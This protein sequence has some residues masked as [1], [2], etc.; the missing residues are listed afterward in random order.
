MDFQTLINELDHKFTIDV[1]DISPFFVE[2]EAWMYS[3]ISKHYKES[4]ESNYRLVFYFEQDFH[5][6]ESY[7]GD[8]A[9]AFQKCITSMDISPFFVTLITSDTET[10]NDLILSKNILATDKQNFYNIDPTVDITHYVA[11]DITCS[12]TPPLSVKSTTN[13]K[14]LWNH[15]HINVNGD[16][17]PCCTSNHNY[18]LGNITQNDI[19]DIYQSPYANKIRESMMAGNKP[20]ACKSC[21]K[22]ESAGFKSPRV[23]MTSDELSELN[24][25]GTV[26]DVIINTIDIRLSNLCNLKCRMCTGN[27][28]SK[29]AKEE[30]DEF[31][32][33]YKTLKFN[34]IKNPNQILELLPQVEE[35][36]FA[37]GEPLL[38]RSH[39][40]I[41]D[42]LINLKKTD[43]RIGYNTNFTV[44]EYKN[45]PIADY[46]SQFSNI[47]VGAS[48]DAMEEHIEYIRHGTMWKDIVYNYDRIINDDTLDI[49]FS[50]TANINIFNAFNLI[51]S[52]QYWIT[53]KELPP[54]K[55]N[56]SILTD[57]PELSI[58]TLPFDYKKKLDT[59]ISNHIKF[60]N[61]HN[62]H[63]L[64][65]QW[66]EIRH[67]LWKS[68]NSAMLPKFFDNVDRLDIL[69]D[70]CFDE[71][72]GEYTDLRKYTNA[73]AAQE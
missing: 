51:H 34:D 40:Q 11:E 29:I 14:K 36:Y 4:Y 69:R 48:L 25:D 32:A 23:A 9:H 7:P 3:A 64:I 30:Y 67:F 39:Y 55:H 65:K 58:Q 50:I 66:E 21:Y 42:E 62:G 8:L 16:V 56:I 18:S 63:G 24:K 57:P 2:G 44:I 49:D 37:G 1:I 35:I 70:E 26:D 10:S 52:Q 15:L 12:H 28:S 73:S 72:F 20:I 71:V 6:Y 22:L 13:C 68:D 43:I 17:L 27:Y 31:G 5:Q 61:G 53:D 54:T 33:E 59:E 19:N 47:H 46:W 38:M 60:L 41:M 45:T